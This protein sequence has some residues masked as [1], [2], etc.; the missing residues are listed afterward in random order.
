M[1]ITKDQDFWYAILAELRAIRELLA[2]D[3]PP[4][5]PAFAQDVELREVKPRTRRTKSASVADR[6]NGGS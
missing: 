6:N 3:G 5:V 4:E 1:P 2:Q